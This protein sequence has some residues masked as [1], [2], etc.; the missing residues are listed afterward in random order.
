MALIIM[1]IQEAKKKKKNLN[2]LRKLTRKVTEMA[3]EQVT[4]RGSLENLAVWKYIERQEASSQVRCVLVRRT[5]RNTPCVTEPRDI[6]RAT[7]LATL[8]LPRDSKV[9]GE[10]VLSREEEALLLSF[11][12][13]VTERLFFSFLFFFC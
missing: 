8:E 1:C 13:Q 2:L 6:S 11:H 5:L 4:S 12:K 9:T 10:R 3:G 7:A